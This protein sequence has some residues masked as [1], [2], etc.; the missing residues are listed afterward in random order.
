MQNW[1]DY[2]FRIQSFQGTIDISTQF[3]GL[4]LVIHRTLK[5]VHAQCI[6]LEQLYRERV[7]NRR[8]PLHVRTYAGFSCVAFV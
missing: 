1:D 7:R 2:A 4:R 5:P 3:I 8:I 6:L